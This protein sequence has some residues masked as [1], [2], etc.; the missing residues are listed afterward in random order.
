MKNERMEHC[1]SKKDERFCN[2]RK[3]VLERRKMREYVQA[4]GHFD[5]FVKTI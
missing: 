3:V 4:H 2:L 5:G 1:S